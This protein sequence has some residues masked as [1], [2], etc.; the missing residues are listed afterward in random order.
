MRKRDGVIV[1]LAAAITGLPPLSVVKA[2]DPAPRYAHRW[3]YCMHNLLV[4][5]NADEVVALIGRAGK[6]G[7]TGVVLA[8]YKFNILGRMPPSYFKNVARV[9]KAAEAA[10][11]EIIPAVFPVGYSA[12]LLAHDPNLAE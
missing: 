9:K 10:H 2:A 4:D 3:V 7:Y 5:R 1:V 6:A 8:D 11:V 12:G